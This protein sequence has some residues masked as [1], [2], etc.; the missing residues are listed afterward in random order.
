M[1]LE[2]ILILVVGI[3]IMCF[4]LLSTIE[5]KLD[6]ELRREAIK[7]GLQEQMVNNHIIFVERTNSP[8]IETK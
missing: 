3:G 7:S 8:T 5:Y 2:K 1:D 4:T 6:D